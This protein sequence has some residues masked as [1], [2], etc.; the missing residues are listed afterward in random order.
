[1]AKRADPKLAAAAAVGAAAVAGA[2][3]KVARERVAHQADVEEERTYRLARD[4]DVAEGIRRIARGQLDDASEHLADASGANGAAGE[5]VHEARKD[6][7]R[8]R[9]VVRLARDQ[10]G[11]EAYRRENALYRD[12]GRSLSGARDSKVLV[13]TLDA[14]IARFAA[15]LAEGAFAALRAQ[16][17]GEAAAEHARLRRD[18]QAIVS[19]LP[20]L[21]AGRDRIATW[22]LADGAAV[23]ALAPGLE[24]I[25]RR[26]RRAARAARRHPSDE[27]LHELRKRAKDL[28][29]AAQI[30]RPAAPDELKRLGRRAH[31]V[32]DVAGEDHDLAVLRAAAEARGAVLRP[33]ELP[34]L[35]ALIDRRQK[36]LRRE[37]L[38]RA[39]RLYRAKPRRLARALG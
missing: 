11:D 24:R 32:S 15:E 30:A 8:A 6:L 5:A 27:T 12:T 36:R 19:A 34:L 18:G 35:R 10:L 21:G 17:A 26:G 7:K 14:L 39:R 25:Y 20:R 13:D 2:L 1:M 16:L 29:H 22:P 38:K 37:A 23:A 3:G 28:W 4:E 33:G 31:R 9:A